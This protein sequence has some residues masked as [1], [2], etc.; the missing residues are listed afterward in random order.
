VETCGKL[1]HYAEWGWGQKFLHWGMSTVPRHHQD[2]RR[3]TANFETHL[4]LN[5]FYDG[6]LSDVH[7]KL[8]DSDGDADRVH[9]VM[10]DLFLALRE[11]RMQ[12][13]AMEWSSL[14]ECCRRHPLC[15]ITQPAMQS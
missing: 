6:F 11:H 1:V 7:S 12:C 5:Q 3:R 14:V 8:I 4:A 2:F 13:S 9:E 10:D 15:S